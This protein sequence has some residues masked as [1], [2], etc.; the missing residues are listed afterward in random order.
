MTVTVSRHPFPTDNAPAGIAALESNAEGLI[1]GLEADS[2][3][4]G[5]AFEL[6]L[7]LAKSH[8]LLDSEASRLSTWKA[9]VTTMQ[10]GSATFAAAVRTDGQVRCRI[11]EKDRVLQATGPQRSSHAGAWLT[12]FYLAVVC[13]E[14]ARLTDL[15]QVPVSLLRESSAPFDEF[16]YSWVETLQDYWLGG[17]ELGTHLVAAMD[18][19]DTSLDHVSDAETTEKILYPPM[20]MLHRL[21]REDHTGFNRALADAVQWHKAY[22]STEDNSLQATGL[23]ALAPLA[24]ACLAYDAGFPIEVASGYLPIALLERDWPGEFPTA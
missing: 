22:W 2:T 19:T 21:V 10:V 16:I 20:E 17:P 1:D 9:W 8:C 5:D 15:C 3:R 6:S 23:V 11:A 4:L 13:R 12:A 14:K 24:V 7:T 18:G